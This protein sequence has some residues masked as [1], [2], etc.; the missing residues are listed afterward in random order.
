M[1]SL[2]EQVRLVPKSQTVKSRLQRPRGLASHPMLG[3]AYIFE[4][5]GA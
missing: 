4:A 2:A 1:L 3:T 5:V